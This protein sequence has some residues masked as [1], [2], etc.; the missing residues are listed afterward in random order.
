M[1]EEWVCVQSYKA[2]TYS[3]HS[4]GSELFLLKQPSYSVI[5]T[6]HLSFTCRTDATLSDAHLVTWGVWI[7]ETELGWLT[8]KKTSDGFPFCSLFEPLRPLTSCLSS[9]HL[10]PKLGPSRST[11]SLVSL[12]NL[13]ISTS[14]WYSG[15][16]CCYLPVP[17]QLRSTKLGDIS[18]HALHLSFSLFALYVCIVFLYPPIPPPTPTP[19]KLWR[20]GGG[21][22]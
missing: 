12:G 8:P 15:S 21:L 1:Y 16:R 19:L 4:L 5:C 22:L 7:R 2:F 9:M 6:E 17:S 18:Q 3:A 13:N 20:G 10:W 11:Q 14:P